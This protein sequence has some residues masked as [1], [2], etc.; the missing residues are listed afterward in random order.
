[1]KKWNVTCRDAAGEVRAEFVVYAGTLAQAFR[2]AARNL[3]QQ[4]YIV[5]VEVE[6]AGTTY[7]D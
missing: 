4:P 3:T 2:E 7:D 6:Y 1:M 5:K